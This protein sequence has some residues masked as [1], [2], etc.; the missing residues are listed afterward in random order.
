MEFVNESGLKTVL[1]RLKQKYENDENYNETYLLL[2]RDLN[3]TNTEN[4][5]KAYLSTL[6]P[7]VDLYYESL[8]N[9]DLNKL[10]KLF[11]KAWSVNPYYTLRMVAYI[12]DIRDGKGE[13]YIG[14]YLFLWVYEK[15]KEIAEL[16]AKHFFNTFGRWDDGIIYKKMEKKT[17][18]NKV[19]KKIE[20]NDFLQLYVKMVVNQIKEDMINLSENKSISLCAKWIP[21][22]RTSNGFIYRMIAKEYGISYEDFRKNVLV[23]LRKKLDLLETKMCEKNYE[24][25]NYNNVPSMAMN[26]HSKKRSKKGIQMDRINVQ[27]NNIRNDTHIEYIECR[28]NAFMR[29]D[30]ERFMEYKENL[31]NGKS[32][33]NASILYPHMIVEKYVSENGRMILDDVDDLLEAQ[34]NEIV[35]K[36]ES[37][38]DL[39]ET[40]VL[41]DVSGSMNG[42]PMLISYSLGILISSLAKSEVWRNMVL[43][44]ES[45]PQ[46]VDVSGDS[47]YERV[48]KIVKAPWGGSTDFKKAFELILKTCIEYKLKQED[49]PKRLIVISDMQFNQADNNMKETSFEMMKREFETN[50]YK[51]PEMV[52]WNVRSTNTTP[53]LANNTNVALVSGYSPNILKS[54]LESKYDSMTPIHIVLN[55]ILNEK[56]DIIRMV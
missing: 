14:R 3:I 38:G 29:N 30:M 40:L 11:N 31:K 17:Y 53:L 39:S 54:V 33:I 28:E 19:E 2:E 8:R 55:T 41:S 44:F 1:E 20:N 47:L 37:I 23:P 4:G 5:D 7:L 43:T 16:N 48:K 52:F 42:T 45:N 27:N 12:R 6:D 22:E 15:S 32:K 25:I 24:E 51:M 35:K 21:S 56:Y 49:V 18:G 26:K 46:F 9:V 10:K 34:W 36:M 50:G 13:K